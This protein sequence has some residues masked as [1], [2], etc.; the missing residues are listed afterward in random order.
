MEES[1]HTGAGMGGAAYGAQ[2]AM[3]QPY[4]QQGRQQHPNL[5]WAGARPSYR[6]DSII[7]TLPVPVRMPVEDALQPP[8]RK[9]S[10]EVAC[11]GNIKP[12]R[13]PWEPEPQKTVAPSLRKTMPAVYSNY[14]DLLRT[15]LGRAVIADFLIG[16]STQ[17]RTGEIAHV[18][19]GYIVLRDPCTEARTGC[20]LH[21]LR[22]L[23]VLPESTQ[24]MPKCDLSAF[25]QL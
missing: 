6:A 16:T 24:Q 2:M 17:R 22:F 15:L 10:V 3:Q 8:A 21:A 25:I 20:D 11:T 4:A 1:Q 12:A 13:M 5:A 14:E 23:T 9:E 7:G 18:G 19:K